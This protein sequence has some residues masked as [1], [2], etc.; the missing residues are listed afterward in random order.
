VLTDPT[1]NNPFDGK[2]QT[3][4]A[5]YANTTLIYSYIKG[6]GGYSDN[7]INFSGF[8]RSGLDD[9]KIE[10]LNVPLSANLLLADT[11]TAT[12]TTSTSLLNYNASA[13]QSGSLGVT[14]WV[15]TGNVQVGNSTPGIDSGNY[16]LLSSGGRAALDRNFNGTVSQGGLK[17]SFDLASNATGNTDQNVWGSFNLGLSSLN[18]L[19]SVNSSVA[20]FGILFRG[21]G[22]I[23]AFDGN[24]DITGGY[25]S[26]GG[27][28]NN[29]TLKP[30][31]VLLTD[32][33]D[34][35]PFD[36]VGQTNIDV[37]ANNTLIY[38]YIKGNGG[39]SDNYINFGGLSVAG[40]DNLK[41]ER[42]GETL[43]VTEGGATDT[44]TVVLNR[45]PTANVTV[46]LNGGTQL[47]TSRSTLT[48]TP[49]NWNIAQTVLVS[50]VEDSVGEGTHQSG[51]T[52]IA[53]STDPNYNGLI[54]QSV[55]ATIIDNDLITTG[56]RSY[57]EQTG[58]AN[59]FKDIDVDYFSNPVLVD[60]DRDRDLDL[61]VGARDGTLRYYANIGTTT[62]PVFSLRTATNSPFSS[63]DVGTVA[64]PTFA[65]I[66]GDG[67]VDLVVGTAEGTLSYFRNNTAV[68]G[69]PSF[70]AQQGSTLNPFDGID[71]GSLSSPVLADI[72]GD[73]DADL[74]VGGWDGTLKYYR[75]T[76][77]FTNPRYIAQTSAANNPFNGIA[78]GA[79]SSPIF[80]EADNDGD[81]DLLIGENNG[82]FT[83]YR[84]TGTAMAP[85][86]TLQA[87]SLFYDIKAGTYVSPALGDLNGDGAL[88]VVAGNSD[89]NLKYFLNQAVATPV[90]PT[91]AF[92]GTNLTINLEQPTT[93]EPPSDF[94][95]LSLNS[96][97]NIVNTSNN[98]NQDLTVVVSDSLFATGTTL[99]VGN[100]NLNLNLNTQT[101]PSFIFASSFRIIDPSST[102]D[103][104]FTDL[105]SLLELENQAIADASSNDPGTLQAALLNIIVQAANKTELERTQ[106][107]KAGVDWLAGQVKQNRIAER[108]KALDLY[109]YWRVHPYTRDQKGNLLPDRYQTPQ[110]FGF[111][112][113]DVVA[114]TGLASVTGL[115]YPP[116]FRQ[117]AKAIIHN[118]LS[119]TLDGQVKTESLIKGLGRNQQSLT[120]A[121]TLFQS[122]RASG[123]GYTQIGAAIYGIGLATGVV[124]VGAYTAALTAAVSTATVATV[125]AAGLVGT[126][127]IGFAASL[128]GISSVVSLA[129]LQT[130]SVTVGSSFLS[131]AGTSAFGVAG[132]IIG[133]VAIPTIT[134]AGGI[135]AAAGYGVQLFG[136][137]FAGYTYEGSV[138]IP[139][140][141]QSELAAA[142]NENIDLKAFLADQTKASEVFTAFIEATLGEASGTYLDNNKLFVI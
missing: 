66:T 134:V 117:H 135:A 109:N 69:A 140:N 116:D 82:N 72:D 70:I 20:H 61:I 49:T 97:I 57:V 92:N 31:T 24:V 112:N 10:R 41:I 21:S 84:N 67:Y 56:I 2:G 22:G 54:V 85:V 68:G 133:T 1:D 7:Y 107:E 123:A 23:Q 105:L 45:A 4:V 106:A 60:V 142:Q 53:S 130:A 126:L 113:Y 95:F 62:D 63:I 29:S 90:G 18:K 11:F 65:D 28:S 79:N 42:L 83:Y 6:N 86:F 48:F 32:P 64:R 43:K 55:A 71:V 19:A 38:S 99:I 132:A 13:R 120:D 138:N 77:S 8:E 128:P 104:S 15:G 75:N 46:T 58:T 36:G 136:G 34:N 100:L 141:L 115:P 127:S 14:N 5:V 129:A 122:M 44:F 76:G 87:G 37:Y 89:G 125:S 26:W 27:T 124:V 59:P 98:A 33:T 40:V 52:A 51:L 114:G 137:T 74:V 91:V 12:G 25:S 16:L 101:E 139:S 94:S 93:P 121:N 30:F 110:G 96:T 39:Y 17:V 35:N 9:L 78:V 80:I 108:Q 47:T 81:F 111:T 50:A 73:G 102:F 103:L 131:A 88:D 119:L 118:N 3:N